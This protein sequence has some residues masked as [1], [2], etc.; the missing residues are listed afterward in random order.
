MGARKARNLAHSKLITVKLEKDLSD[1]G[2][3]DDDDDDVMDDENN[4]MM[5]VMMIMIRIK[6]L[7]Y[8]KMFCLSQQTFVLMKTS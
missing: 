7:R 2:F 1:D 3:V 4:R 6:K 8:S 5:M